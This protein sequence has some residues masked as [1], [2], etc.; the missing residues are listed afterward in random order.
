MPL[1]P[2]RVPHSLKPRSQVRL[3]EAPARP[4]N[5]AAVTESQSSST[6]FDPLL[7]GRERQNW[8]R[9]SALSALELAPFQPA[10]QIVNNAEDI[11]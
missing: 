3:S 11:L 10:K 7:I 2:D 4:V 6:R 9:Q 8:I 1:S 5:A